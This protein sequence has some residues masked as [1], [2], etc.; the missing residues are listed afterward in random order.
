M[1]NYYHRNTVCT[2]VTDK[3]WKNLD[4]SDIQ[5]CLNGFSFHGPSSQLFETSMSKAFG[6]CFSL[7]V[8][9]EI[10]VKMYVQ[11]LKQVEVKTV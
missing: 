7:L 11:T 10:W 5:L 1:L 9:Y 4:K 8:I 6:L 3:S 2:V